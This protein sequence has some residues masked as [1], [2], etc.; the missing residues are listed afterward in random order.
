MVMAVS[1]FPGTISIYDSASLTSRIR[2]RRARGGARVLC[3]IVAVLAGV[4]LFVGWGMDVAAARG[5]ATGSRSMAITT[6][7]G[8]LLC[9][10]LTLGGVSRR[11][12]VR[13]GSKRLGAGFLLCLA[14]AD[15][16]LLASPLQIGLDQFLFS[17]SGALAEVYMSPAT[18]T[19]LMLAAGCLLVR[20]RRG[21]FLNGDLY[22]LLV[23]AG[24]LVTTLALVGYAFDAES[25]YA[26]FVYTAMSLHTAVGF[27]LMFVALMLARPTWGWMFLVMGPGPGG[28]TL[29]RTLP[30]VVLGP[31]AFCGLTLAAVEAGIFDVNFRL[32]LLAITMMSSLVGLLFWSAQRE[33]ADA[34]DI[35]A[36]NAQLRRLLHERDVLLQEVYHRVK[37]NLQFID[38]MLALEAMRG[39]DSP[40]DQ[41]L[42]GIRSRL[43]AI[44]L[45]HQK[46]ISAQDLATV[47]LRSFLTDLCDQQGRGAG[48]DDRGISIDTSVDEIGLDLEQAVPIGLL[49]TELLSNAAKHA[50][51][52]GRAGRIEV[53][54][55]RIDGN[56]LQLSVSDNGV[57][58]A[59]PAGD[60]GTVGSMI[61]RSLAAQ[62]RAQTRRF[63]EDGFCIAFTIP[64]DKTPRS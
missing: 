45:V 51:P 2:A 5:E 57:G 1:P 44:S 48:L 27:F 25:L 18:A 6:A 39:N 23:L 26:V 20:R 7:V 49:V 30:F 33:N 55:K 54:A 11:R 63:G 36:A 19:C 8:L 40:L 50:F 24:L 9:A 13:P 28:A 37:N 46:L 53:V 16:A 60:G 62:L 59:G 52:D 35:I 15:L 38:A 61:V 56:R 29:R 47:D 10:L 64:L 41:R 34:K 22:G 12:F 3:A 17:F 31:F 32:S 58:L 4:V 21:R 43:H 42:A 14:L